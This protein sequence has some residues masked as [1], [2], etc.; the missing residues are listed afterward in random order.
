MVIA[1]ELEEMCQ[2]LSSF[3]PHILQKIFTLFILTFLVLVME[4]RNDKVEPAV[5]LECRDVGNVGM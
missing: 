4:K 2:V 5:S 1:A 3:L